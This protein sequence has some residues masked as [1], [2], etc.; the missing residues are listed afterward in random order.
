MA[1]PVKPRPLRLRY[2]AVSIV[3]GSDACAQ[4]KALK[5]VRLLSLSAPRLPIVGCTSPESCHCK[6][7]HHTDRR[8]GP[9][10]SG[11]RTPMPGAASTDDNRRRL[12]GRRD[13]DY[14]D[15]DE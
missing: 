15:V 12:P 3:S 14:V 13:S 6:F 10:R 5:G 9:R 4:A 1:S 7:Q 11:L 2:H 8:A